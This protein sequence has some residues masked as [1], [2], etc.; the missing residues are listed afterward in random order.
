MKQLVWVGGLVLVL[1]APVQA[2]E[3]ELGGSREDLSHG[4]ADWRSV[5]LA[6]EQQFG[7]RRSLYGA[8]RQ[9]KRFGQD[10]HEAAAGLALPLDERWTLSSDGTA[11]PSH[12]VLAK[13]SFGLD[14]HRRL[15]EG[16]GLSL[17]GRHTEYATA[18]TERLSLGLE[19]YFG[20]Y[21]AA[22]VGSSTHLGGA[23]WSSAHRLELTQYYGAASRVGI[24]LGHGR[25]AEN[26]PPRG[27]LT[28]TVTVL[29][30]AGRHWLDRDWA[31]SYEVTLLDQGELYRRRGL[32]LGLRRAF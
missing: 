23:G 6:G 11:S 27:V 29:A 26:L 1:G 21:R 10:D 31:L 20:A 22:Y 9:T 12:H 16:W 2:L 30:V 7:E 3:L 13:W 32:Q 25:E 8:W 18:E 17:G 24:V 4:L 19:R 28:S 14:L 15:D 5:Y